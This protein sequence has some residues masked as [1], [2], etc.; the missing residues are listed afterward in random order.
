MLLAQNCCL[1]HVSVSVSVWKVYCGKPADWIWM[2]FGV[3]SAV[4]RGMGVLDGGDD[5]QR[6]RGIYVGEFGA[7]HYSQ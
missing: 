2:P 5:W 7:S 6:G 4:G 3:V 1:S